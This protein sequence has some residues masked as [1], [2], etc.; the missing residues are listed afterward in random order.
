MMLHLRKTKIKKISSSS[1]IV[2]IFFTYIRTLVLFLR[3]A[4]PWMLWLILKLIYTY[5]TYLR[6]EL[7]LRLFHILLD[8]Y[9]IQQ[10]QTGAGM[11]RENTAYRPPQ[12]SLN[13]QAYM[14]LQKIMNIREY[15]EQTIHC[16][17]QY[18]IFFIIFNKYLVL[19]SQVLNSVL[20]LNGF[21]ISNC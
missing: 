2:N 8:S 12:Q 3:L 11:C 18:L 15:F 10:H 13:C 9:G 14:Q 7:P 1:L 6:S 21:M 5:S 20:K 19:N 16:Y 17:K 4:T